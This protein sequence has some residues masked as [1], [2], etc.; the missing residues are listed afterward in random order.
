MLMALSEHAERVPFI[1]DFPPM[2]SMHREGG[3]IASTLLRMAAFACLMAA[4]TQL[5]CQPSSPATPAANVESPLQL[6]VVNTEPEVT[7]EEGVRIVTLATKEQALR[8]IDDGQP[9]L[10][11]NLG[12]RY[13]GVHEEWHYVQ[14]HD[15]SFI[16]RFHISLLTNEELQTQL[17][18]H[19]V[20]VKAFLDAQTL[21]IPW[22]S[23]RRPPEELV[24]W[25]E[26]HGFSARNEIGCF[27][28]Q[29]CQRHSP[30]P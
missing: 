30:Q 29:L 18:V 23:G 26:T 3:P 22:P 2:K 28:R 25:R 17:K 5:A 1:K 8:A 27:T 19:G 15:W 24:R 16:Y 10:I 6:D 11:P 21:D 12:S 20:R 4:T 9:L 7:Y 14:P 13:L